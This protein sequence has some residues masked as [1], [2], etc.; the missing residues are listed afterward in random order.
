MRK[1]RMCTEKYYTLL[2]NVKKFSDETHRVVMQRNHLRIISEGV[3]A[4][5]IEMLQNQVVE[6]K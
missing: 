3:E 1:R 5:L 6:L 4:Q 2:D